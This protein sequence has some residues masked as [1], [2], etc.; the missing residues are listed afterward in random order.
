MTYEIMKETI[1]K[2]AIDEIIIREYLKIF[3]GDAYDIKVFFVV[4]N[5]SMLERS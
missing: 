4:S 3:L 1:K 5:A 2:T